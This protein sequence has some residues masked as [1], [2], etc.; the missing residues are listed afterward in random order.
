MHSSKKILKTV[1]ILVICVILLKGLDMA[2]YPCTFMRNDVHAVVT[3]QFDDII[4]G[5]SHGK[6]DID[7]EV[8]EEITGRTGHNLCVGGEYGIDAYYLARLVAEKQNP[9]RII[10]EVDPGYFVSEKE[11]GNN[12]LLFYHEFPFSKAKL[13]YFW[14]SIAKCNF[15]TILFPWYDYSLSYE[16]PKVK[17]TFLQKIKKDYSITD[18]KSDSQEYHESG[19]IERYPVDTSK[20][21]K[22]D[23]KLYEDGKVALSNMEYLKKLIDFC[24]ENDIEFVAVTTPVP[25]ATL[26]DHSDNYNA[27]W[28]YFGKFFEEQGVDYI[29]FNTQYFKAFTHNAKAYT[30][31]DGHMNGDAARAYSKVL[32]QV[33][34]QTESA[35]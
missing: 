33:L 10:Y 22:T 19:F 4:L 27:A 8:M 29:N 30:D 11:E 5:T 26:K 2:L 35:D 32:A 12:Y 18:L 28:K 24:K 14:N 1:L 9:K 15:R 34:N 3:E 23:I 13:E 21:K 6:M 17:E 20:L 31:Y 25:I 16:V 7:P